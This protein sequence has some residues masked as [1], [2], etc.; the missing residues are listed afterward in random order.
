MNQCD[1]SSDARTVHLISSRLLLASGTYRSHDMRP[2]TQSGENVKRPC[3][4]MRDK[5]IRRA[6]GAKVK[7]NDCATTATPVRENMSAVH[8]LKAMGNTT[9]QLLLTVERL[10]CPTAERSVDQWPQGRI[11]EARAAR[12]FICC[13]KHTGKHTPK[14]IISDNWTANCVAHWVPPSSF[15][16]GASPRRSA[17]LA[18]LVAAIQESGSSKHSESLPWWADFVQF[19]CFF[20]LF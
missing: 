17:S 9:R 10:R 4:H 11:S 14:K 12:L 18:A 16:L 13:H 8:F 3:T 2:H 6:A 15:H 7:S 20:F 19:G 1:F 5:S